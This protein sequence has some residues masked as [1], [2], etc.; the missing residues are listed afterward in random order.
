MN[1][2]F[3][4]ADKFTELIFEDRNKSYGA[5]ALRK[6]QK[7]NIAF[8]LFITIA[9]FG[10]MAWLAISLTKTT[11]EIPSF[12]INNGGII[13]N[14]PEIVVPKPIINPIQKVDVAPKTTSGQLVASDD[15]QK[16]DHKINDLLVINKNPNPF[17]S[18]SAAPKDPEIKAPPVL[19][20]KKLE[21]ITYAEVMPKLDNMDQFIH[22]HLKYPRIAVENGTVGTVYVTFVVEA[23]GSITNIK[24]LKGIGDGCEQEAMRVVA[25]MPLWEPGT[26]KNVPQRVQCNLPIKF[27]LK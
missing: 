12:E 17:G 9:F 18:D 11:I 23:D 16:N 7:D 10:L 4:S 6:T 25:L 5:Y 13:I 26:I 8:S 24:L 27:R 15:K 3:N 1:L 19:P 22:D 2:Q 21:I 20:A 14:G